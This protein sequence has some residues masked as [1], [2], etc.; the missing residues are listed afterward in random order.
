MQS[1]PD[2]STPLQLDASTPTSTSRQRKRPPSRHRLVP[3]RPDPAGLDG[4]PELDQAARVE[5]TRNVCSANRADGLW[6]GKVGTAGCVLDAIRSSISHCRTFSD[7]PDPPPV[8]ITFARKRSH[9]QCMSFVAS[10]VFADAQFWVAFLNDQDQS[11]AAAQA[12]AGPCT[13]WAWS[14][15]KKCSR[16]CRHFSASVASISAN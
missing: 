15:Q 2:S 13:V 1:I 6:A 12:L 16:K 14:R 8:E 7:Y 10:P 5:L 4:P 11:H 3:A 9:L